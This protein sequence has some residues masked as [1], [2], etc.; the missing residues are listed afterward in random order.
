M[1]RMLSSNEMLCGKPNVKCSVGVP[2]DNA[3]DGYLTFS[4]MP[5][6]MEYRRSH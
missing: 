6:V 4:V 1:C 2:E 3:L 5:V